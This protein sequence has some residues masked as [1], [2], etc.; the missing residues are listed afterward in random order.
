M[1]EFQVASTLQSLVPSEPGPWLRSRLK[2]YLAILATVVFGFFFV[3]LWY[4]APTGQ[5]SFS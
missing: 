5:R 2:V 4:A 1:S 3:A